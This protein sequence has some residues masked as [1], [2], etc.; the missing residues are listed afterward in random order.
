MKIK[1]VFSIIL[2]S[3]GLLFSGC[4]DF[5]TTEPSVDLTDD[6]TLTNVTG[7]TMLLNGTYM[8]MKNG[9]GDL[10]ASSPIGLKSY[11]TGVAS[12]DIASYPGAGNEI[13]GA[14]Q[15]NESS[16]MSIGRFPREFYRNYY[17]IINNANLLI[18][19]AHN[20]GVKENDI[21]GQALIIRA[22]CYYNLVRLYQ[23]TYTLAKDKP[24]VPIYLEPSNIHAEPKDRSTVEQVYARI[25][26]DL[27]DALELLKDFSRSDWTYYDTDVANFLLAD[28]YLTKNEW[29]K[30]RDAANKITSKYSLM[31]NAQYKNGFCIKNDEWILGY[32]Q[33]S[34]DS[35]YYNSIGCVWYWEDG[36]QW[37]AKMFYPTTNFADNILTS[38]D[39]RYLFRNITSQ[40]DWYVC[41]KFNDR[42]LGGQ[43]ILSDMCD[44]RA[45]EMYLVEAEARA[46]IPGEEATAL[47]ILNQIQTLRNGTI[48]TPS[49]DL[50]EAIY[51]ER[52]KELYG[53]G[54]DI[55]DAKRLQK[56][57]KRVEDKANGGHYYTVDIPANSN[58]LVLQIPQYEMTNNPNIKEQN[59]DPSKTPV[60]VP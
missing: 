12:I 28:V 26:E 55:W 37:A 32:K 38:T 13:Y 46:H 31:S 47:T 53:E 35:W 14:Y 42:H 34:D 33:T 16:Y 11:S 22:R 59:P 19:N 57:I 40:P 41:D 52:R 49:D 58:K 25:E 8:K 50:L 4:D 30:A 10:H 18:A 3:G 5:L 51:L 60:F 9:N 44:L 56:G 15:F 20:A 17:E 21:K 48:T 6:V 43:P 29:A 1:E 36:T 39:A 54:I 7:L 24:G 2:L 27:T 45:A 23:H